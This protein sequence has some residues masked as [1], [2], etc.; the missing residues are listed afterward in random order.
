VSNIM[1]SMDDPPKDVSA[2]DSSEE[3][4]KLDEKAVV[5][6]GYDDEIDFAKFPMRELSFTPTGF[7]EPVAFNPLVSLIGCTLL[8]GLAIWSMGK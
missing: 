1:S 4:K 8:W 6:P 2:G 7:K 3:L 5:V